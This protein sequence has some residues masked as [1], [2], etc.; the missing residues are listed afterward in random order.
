MS[1]LITAALALVTFLQAPSAATPSDSELK[2]RAA[3]LIASLAARD[4]A[5][6]V[7]QF[8]DAMKA[9][10]PADRLA[11]AW[12]S[13]QQQ[14]GAFK[15]CGAD[16]RIR[17]VAD[18]RMVITPC[19]FARANADVQFAFAADGKVSGFAV[20]PPDAAAAPYALP[21]YATPSSYSETEVT[22]G[23]GE[24]ARPG[25]LTLPAGAGPFAAVILVHGSGPSDRNESVGA[26]KPFADLA[27]G[28]ASRGIAVLRYEK[29]TRV[30][31]SR[32]AALPAMTV[33]EETLEDALLAAAL[34]RTQPKVDPARIFVLGHSVGGMLVPR[35]VAADAKLAGAIVMAGAARPIDQ[36]IV[37][38]TTYLANADGVVTPQEQTQIDQAVKLQQAVAALTPEDAASGRRVSGAPAAYWLDLRGYDA[39]TAA[40]AVKIPMLILQG[41]RDYQV[42]M[43][44]FARWKAALDGRSDVTFHSYPGLNHLFVTGEGKSL[45]AE[46]DRPSHVSEEVIRDIAG[47]IASRQSSSR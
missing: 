25:T 24:W 43:D 19:E 27:L 12:D 17:G 45:P 5:A 37:E 36:A 7:T 11:A 44:E 34:L 35:I 16:V 1:F 9:A 32:M 31:G 23:A 22:V 33:K 15:S 2:A 4:M 10:L 8:D 29:R 39:P 14:A 3:T 41:E 30:Y 20:R 18:K 38:Q 21:S 47:W 42:T 40:K 46:Y 6:V 28:L 26:N 13:L